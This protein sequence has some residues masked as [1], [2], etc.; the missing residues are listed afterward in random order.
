MSDWKLT[1][2]PVGEEIVFQRDSSNT[3]ETGV[4]ELSPI[5]EANNPPDPDDGFHDLYNVVGSNQ[6]FVVRMWRYVD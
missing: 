6:A 3:V 1:P 4:L 5:T 2:P